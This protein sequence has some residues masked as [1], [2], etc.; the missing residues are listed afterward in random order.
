MHDH[1]H[2]AL[3]ITVFRLLSHASVQIKPQSLM[4]SLLTALLRVIRGPSWRSRS[5][6]ASVSL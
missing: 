4:S 1:A 5:M 6:L 3:F 2:K